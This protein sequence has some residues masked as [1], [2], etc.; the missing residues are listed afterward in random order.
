MRRR[1]KALVAGVVSLLLLAFCVSPA[2]AHSRV[3]PPPVYS[4]AERRPLEAASNESVLFFPLTASRT[5][6]NRRE[7]A[8]V[9]I[10]DNNRTAADYAL[11]LSTVRCYALLFGY[12]LIEVELEHEREHRAACAGE[13]FMFRRHCVITRLM[14]ER[15]AVEWFVFLDA[16][17]SVVNPDRLLE[18]FVDERADLFYDRLFNNEIAA[19]S[20]VARNSPFARA[21]L[22]RWAAYESPAT[23]G[24][25]MWRDNGVI[26]EVFLD[27]FCGDCAPDWRRRCEELRQTMSTYDEL[28]RYESCARALLGDAEWRRSPNG[29]LR[30]LS[31]GRGYWVRDGWLTGSNKRNGEWTSPFVAEFFPPA[32]CADRRSAHLLW[33]YRPEF[34]T[35]IAETSEQLERKARLSVDGHLKRLQELN[36]AGTAGLHFVP[37]ILGCL[38]LFRE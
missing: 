1:W 10:V 23:A 14:V 21:F 16:D 11:A 2:L 28:V 27:F 6:E 37:L 36:G 34:R 18:E 12:P 13:D 8:L 24:S 15:P 22:R 35:T 30:Q 26:S 3:P 7:I 32:R 25:R 33:A 20:Y 17:M 19:G 38:L 29:T 5:A 31:G 9:V 4:P